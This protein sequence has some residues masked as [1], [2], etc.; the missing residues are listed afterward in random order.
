MDVPIQSYST[1]S[2][3]ISKHHQV[4]PHL[5]PTAYTPL[6]PHPSH[7]LA[8][9]PT[10]HTYPTSIPPNSTPAPTLLQPTR[11]DPRPYTQPSV[12]YPTTR[13]TLL[14]PNQTRSHSS[15]STQPYPFRIVS[16]SPNPHPS[17]PYMPNRPQR[18]ASVLAMLRCH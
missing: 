11:P 3:P 12:H 1:Y 10:H 18:L 2:H 5:S 6:T 15:T 7:H 4:C 8:Q 17:Y 9:T 14:P 16:Y 13:H